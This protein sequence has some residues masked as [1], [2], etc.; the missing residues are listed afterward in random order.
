VRGV[1]TSLSAGLLEACDDE[2]LFG[3]KLTPKQRELLAE[4]EAGGILHCWALGRRSG[5]TMLAAAIGLW[6]LLLRPELREHVRRRECIYAVGVATN[7]R[8]AR[9]F[10]EAALAIVEGSPVLTPL[11]ERVTE[12]Q[13]QF[14]NRS[15]LAAF[16]CTSRGGRGWPVVA[17]LQDEAAH[18]LDSEGNQAAEPIFRAMTP[19][20]AQFGAA[21]RVVVASTPYGTDGFFAE[22]F[23]SIERGELDGAVCARAS[24]LEARPD[25]PSELLAL[26]ERR[27]PEG[28]RSEYA[29]EFVQPGGTFLDASLV[30]AAVT[31][32]SELQP[33]EV[34]DPEAAIDL[35]FVH[36]ATALAIVGRDRDNP[37]RQRL[38]LARSW[39]PDLGPL[40]FGPTLDEIADICIAY[41]V[42]H[43]HT[44]QYS[45]TAAVEHLARRGVRATVVPTTPA[46]KSEMFASLK[47]RIYAGELE[48]YE[49]T[50]LLAELNRIET[51][52][53]PG[54]ASVRIRRLGSSHGD[55]ATAVA[56]ASSKVRTGVRP[57][58]IFVAKGQIDEHGK[59]AGHPRAREAALGLVKF[60][61]STGHG[62]QHFDDMGRWVG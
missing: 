32:S 15:T 52:M 34:E 41:G 44:D 59:Y 50:D 28:F 36:D 49:Q 43:L 60:G 46:S 33:G 23:G 13:I 48:L 7:L 53:S 27:D 22:L 38:V 30:V 11:I 5:K 35:G 62:S 1:E 6:C 26:E 14:A 61:N 16:P 19:S 21:A 51:V 57:R 31:R 37:D 18:Q 10:V 55:L 4:V 24:T 45:A 8:Q 58:G 39:K 42:R 47:Q 12:D 3:V 2:R 25:F 17:F 54:S 20:V 40:G 29:A 9:I 56:L